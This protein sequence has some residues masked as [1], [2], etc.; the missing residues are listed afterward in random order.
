MKA[1]WTSYLTSLSFVSSSTWREK[2]KQNWVQRVAG[3]INSVDASLEPGT[4]DELHKYSLVG[5]L[6][7]SCLGRDWTV[8]LE[9]FSSLEWLDS[10]VL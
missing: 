2:K 7:F 9:F 3:K 1:L 6:F 8:S 4:Q 10:T 5:L